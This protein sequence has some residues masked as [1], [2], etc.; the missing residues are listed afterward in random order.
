MVKVI[1]TD[2]A[3]EDLRQI[4]HF[5]SKDSKAYADR[6]IE[7]LIGRVGQLENFPQ[8]GRIVPELGK[9]DL[10]E[11]IE[12]NYRII[13]KAGKDQAAILRIHHS[14]RILDQV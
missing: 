11:L 10:R 3:I 9:E 1:W 12:G 4:H 2:V 5:I 7:K 6:F 13:F 8:S 14:A